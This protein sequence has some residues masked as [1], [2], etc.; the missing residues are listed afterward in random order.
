MR[1]GTERKSNGICDDVIFELR[2]N[3]R[4]NQK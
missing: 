3:K 2:N 4:K 1:K